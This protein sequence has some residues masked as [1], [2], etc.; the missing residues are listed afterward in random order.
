MCAY[1][2]K[3]FTLIEMLVVIAI[4]GILASLMMPSLQS[5]MN[6]SRAISCVSNMK[7][8]GAATFSHVNNNDGYLPDYEW[9]GFW[10]KDLA[11]EAGIEMNANCLWDNNNWLL[12]QPLFTC[13]TVPY[14]LLPANDGCPV[15][16]NYVP[17]LSA[18]RESDA[19][20][21][22]GGFQSFAQNGSGGVCKKLN[23]VTPGSVGMIET[24]P[25]RNINDILL[26]AQNAYSFSSNFSSIGMLG[27]KSSST[28]CHEDQSSFLFVDGHV[29]LLPMGTGFN[30][31]WTVQ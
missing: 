13:P 1:L 17:T 29:E 27:Q 18:W 30:T 28:Y 25:T 26:P 21:V 2:R 14:T 3:C 23:R 7:G 24:Y 8:V 20:G 9:V 6:T 4:I 10:V 19:V 22:Y 12:T 31:D 5:A 16:Y 15:A 11:A